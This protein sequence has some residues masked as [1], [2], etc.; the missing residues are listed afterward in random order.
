[1]SDAKTCGSEDPLYLDVLWQLATAGVLRPDQ[2]AQFKLTDWGKQA[3]ED[4]V[5]PYLKNEFLGDV[6]RSAPQLDEDSAAYLGLALDC[7]YSVP[8]ASPGFD[9]CRS[10]TRDRFG[11]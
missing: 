5:S 10:R 4:D 6:M 11:H 1:M 9:P 2:R 7:V 3:I 8:A